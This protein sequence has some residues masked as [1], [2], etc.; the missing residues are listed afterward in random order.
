MNEKKRDLR[1]DILRF[2]AIIGIIVA[3]STPPDWLFELRNFDV[4]LIIMMM[5]ASFYI[6]NKGKKQVDYIPYAIKRFKRLIIPTWEFL[7]F[8]F[9]LFYIISLVLNDSYYF[10]INK[11]VFSFL[12][13]K[14]IGFVWIM[15]VFFSV[16]LA[17]PIILLISKK[18]KST[19]MYFGWIII[20]YLIYTLFIFLGDI[21]LKGGV[22][23][24]YNQVFLYGFGYILVAAIGIRLVVMNKRELIY[25]GVVTFMIYAIFAISS[26]FPSTQNFKYTPTIYYISYGVFASVTLYLVISIKTINRLLSNNF[27][28]YVSRN[29][30][31]LYFWHIIPIYIVRLFGQK[32]ILTSSFLAEFSFIFF[33]ALILTYLHNILSNYIKVKKDRG[34]TEENR[35][36]KSRPCVEEDSVYSRNM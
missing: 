15:G 31:W 33:S 22:Y 1:V 30:L 10:D 14:G 32:T 20:G 13:I 2:I 27:F 28:M 6:S 24:L 7:S 18:T 5:G 34:H 29:S 35:A 11:I 21:F 26:N 17:S 4:T 19:I 9:I 36:P 3:H 8:F 12:T 23:T 16:A 25:L